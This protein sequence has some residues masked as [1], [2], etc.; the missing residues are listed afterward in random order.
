MS[1]I[2]EEKKEFE[3]I[4]NSMKKVIEQNNNLLKESSLKIK[5]INKEYED[6]KNQSEKDKKDYQKELK[7]LKNEIEEV[8]ANNQNQNQ[9]TNII[10]FFFQF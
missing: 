10:F 8:K 2:K 4:L 3:T 6:L 1:K 7:K 5:L 9:I